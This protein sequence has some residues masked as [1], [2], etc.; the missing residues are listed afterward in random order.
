MPLGVTS[1][2]RFQIF[3]GACSLHRNTR[4]SVSRLSIFISTASLSPHQP[5]PSRMELQWLLRYTV[6]ADQI[7]PSLIYKRDESYLQ[8]VFEILTGSVRG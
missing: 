6:G 5:P 3:E 8:T 7:C 2:H 1:I 4:P